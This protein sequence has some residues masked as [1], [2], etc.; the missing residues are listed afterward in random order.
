MYAVRV[1]ALV[2]VITQTAPGQQLSPPIGALDH[3][4]WTTRDGAPAGITA[5]AQSADGLLWIGTT[6][7]LYRFDGVRFEPV[8][9]DSGG[10]TAEQLRA[11]RP[12]LVDRRGNTWVVG[13]TGLVRVPPEDAGQRSLT[14]KRRLAETVPLSTGSPGPT[15]FEDREGNVWVATSGGIERFRET[16]L[17]PVLLPE[18]LF[19]PS[20]AP[21][22]DS[23]VWVGSQSHP[24]LVIAGNRVLSNRDVPTGLTSAYRDLRGGVW[25]GGSSGV[26]HAPAGT[27]ASSASFTPVALPDG[28]GSGEVQAIARTLAGELW[29]SIR[30]GRRNGVFRRRGGDWLPVRLPPDLSGEIASPI[31]ADS[32]GR[33]WL[34]LGNSLAAASGD[35]IH[36]YSESDGLR[37]GSISAVLVRGPRVWVGG[38]FGLTMLADGR[39]QRVN[40]TE[41]LAGISGIVETAD[42]DLWLNGA[43]GITH[44]V[45]AEVRRALDSSAYRARSERFDQR[46]GLRGSTSDPRPL[47]TAIQGADG[48]LWFTTATGVAWLDPARINRNTVAPPVFIAV[49]S[50]DGTEYPSAGPVALPARTRALRIAYGA[51]SFTIPD[52]IRFRYRLAG[53]DTGWVEAGTRREAIYTNLD[54]G[55]YRFRVIAANEDNVW[56]EA[57]TALSFEVPRAFTQTTAFLVLVATVAAGSVVLLLALQRR[58][59]VVATPAAQVAAA[60]RPRAATRAQP[61]PLPALHE[62]LSNAATRTLAS[63]GITAHVEPVGSPRPYPPNVETEIVRIA[64]EAMTNARQHTSCRLVTITCGYA[65]RELRVRVHDDGRGFDLTHGAPPSH[66]DLARMREQAASIGAQ[67]SVESSPGAGTEIVLVVPGVPARWTWWNKAIPSTEVK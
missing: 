5:F 60:R 65:P 44:I 56:N 40:A 10:A 48:R 17:T 55:S 45:A 59:R 30:G 37:V 58:Q 57:G 49:L 7:G 31:V 15:P 8:P 50:A 38:E 29:V 18:S 41:S 64:T 35:S 22:A 11:T 62:Q 36:L 9:R 43:A 3:A 34:G 23:S 32:A 1:L 47:P 14:T 19:A 42:G 26:W 33:V 28:S 54:P 6:S 20:L 12:S 24:L 16:K 61:E 51:I 67:F 46:D 13:P 21:S 2:F 39:F 25:L 53:V 4:V 27:F 63:A 52:R 66:W